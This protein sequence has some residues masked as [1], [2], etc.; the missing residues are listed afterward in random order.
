VRSEIRVFDGYELWKRPPGSVATWVSWVV[1]LAAALTI[2][3][4]AVGPHVLAKFL[5]GPGPDRFWLTNGLAIGLA[6][7]IAA[8][9]AFGGRLARIV[10]VA[11]LL[12]AVHLIAMVIAWQLWQ[13]F[14]TAMPMAAAYTPYTRAIPAVEAAVVVG[15]GIV[16]AACGY[17][18]LYR[19]VAATSHH[20]VMAALLAFLL[21]GLWLPIAALIWH[22][23][24]ARY[25]FALR[26]TV[27]PFVAI[28]PPIAAAV[29]ATIAVARW[30]GTLLRLRSAALGAGVGLVIAS[31]ACRAAG[32]SR[33][34]VVYGNFVHVIMAAGML[35]VL[36]IAAL[37]GSWVIARSR[38]RALY[39]G[40]TLTGTIGGPIRPEPEIVARVEVAS[41]L[42][43]PRIVTHPFAVTTPIATVPVPH[44]IE[45]VAP[46]PT[47]T[48]KLAVGESTALLAAGDRVRLA[49]YV[50]PPADHPYRGS[51][52][53][54]PGP[55]GVFV[56]PVGGARA[57]GFVDLALSV[58]RPC[59]S[60]L[61]IAAT[62]VV[63]AV[64]PVLR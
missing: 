61:L 56:E 60:Y 3:G 52:A 47:V 8:C 44:G 6:V 7:A 46:I 10:H 33:A 64:L 22:D 43:G 29:L 25:T 57:G 26:T 24:L 37:G 13:R 20:V 21:L 59:V 11:V 48:T 18:A 30:P 38:S 41:W 9:L 17:A 40:R 15:A 1:G 28:I 4:A 27:L 32:G 39:A 5:D 16:I 19:R 2:V 62:I 63:I 34:F 12:P 49:G 55:D 42:R 45:I 58:W 53:P 23:G 14:Q 50:E 35:A 31:V 54:V 36:S 51:S